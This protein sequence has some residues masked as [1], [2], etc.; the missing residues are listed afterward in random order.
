MSY[1]IENRR[2]PP[3]LMPGAILC[4]IPQAAAMIGRG[5]SFVYEALGDGRIEARKSD[6][7]TLVVVESLRIYPRFLPKLCDWLDQRGWEKPPPER[8]AK[9]SKSK[10]N[11]HYRNGNKFD[12][13]GFAL[14]YVGLIDADNRVVQ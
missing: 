9:R 8:G 4:T 3:P 13:A 12:G 5:I 1:S 14:K 6:G 10:H 11:G 7:R 2:S